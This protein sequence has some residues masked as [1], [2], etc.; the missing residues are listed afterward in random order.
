MFNCTLIIVAQTSF[1]L[2]LIFN[3]CQYTV[4]LLFSYHCFSLFSIILK[5]LDTRMLV[6]EYV[7]RFFSWCTKPPEKVIWMV[8]WASAIVPFLNFK[9]FWGKAYC[10]AFNI[11]ELQGVKLRIRPRLGD[12]GLKFLI[13]PIVDS[14]KTFFLISSPIFYF[15]LELLTVAWIFS[16]KVA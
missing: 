1:T 7:H 10:P 2:V 13:Y 5:S 8:S 3:C 16:L 15:S 9:I 14:E 11:F 12:M 6:K 4:L